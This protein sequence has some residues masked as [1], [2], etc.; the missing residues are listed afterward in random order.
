MVVKPLGR[1]RHHY[2]LVQRMAH[3]TGADLVRAWEAGELRPRDWAAMVGRCRG[4]PRARRCER[5]LALEEAANPPEFCLN[6]KKLKE[7][8]Q[9]GH[10]GG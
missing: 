10:G 2:W 5:L 4:C 3:A 9:S 8:R 6:S 7:I 1:P